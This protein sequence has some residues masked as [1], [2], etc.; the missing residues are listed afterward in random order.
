MKMIKDPKTK[1]RFQKNENRLGYG[2]LFLVIISC[3]LYP[4]SYYSQLYLDMG[5]EFDYTI[6]T[7][8]L[9]SYDIISVLFVIFSAGL[10]MFMLKMKYQ[11]D[12]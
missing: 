9:S 5:S 2:Y 1:K 8:S 10:L 12:Y 11:D 7:I 6:D 4:I 3:V